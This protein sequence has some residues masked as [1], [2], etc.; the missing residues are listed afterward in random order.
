MSDFETKMKSRAYLQAYS[1]QQSGNKPEVKGVMYVENPSDR[2]FWEEVV[3]QVWPKSYSVKLLVLEEK[4]RWKKNMINFTPLILLG[5]MVI[6]IFSV[7][8][9]MRMRVK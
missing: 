1:R 2:I 5:W 3:S 6:L 8:N 4:E 7:R 9:V